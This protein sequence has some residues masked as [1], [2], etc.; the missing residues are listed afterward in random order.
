MTI[1]QISDR[2]AKHNEISISIHNAQQKRWA[3]K[4]NVLDNKITIVIEWA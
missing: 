3:V 4:I 2:K 1:N